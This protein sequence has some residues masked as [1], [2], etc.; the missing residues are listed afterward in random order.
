MYTQIITLI[1]FTAASLLKMS[2]HDVILYDI[3]TLDIWIT[4]VF[5]CF[6]QSNR[7]YCTAIFAY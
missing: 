1:I 7:S 3:S 5:Y 2:P 6:A 4:T